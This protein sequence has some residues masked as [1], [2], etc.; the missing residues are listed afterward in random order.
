VLAVGL[1]IFGTHTSKGWMAGTAAT[2]LT[3]AATA[4]RRDVNMVVF[5][6]VGEVLRGSDALVGCRGAMQTH[7][8]PRLTPYK[9][10]VRARSTSAVHAR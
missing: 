4:T 7:P 5:I 10:L 3:M 6:V 8:P 1:V 2:E 9:P